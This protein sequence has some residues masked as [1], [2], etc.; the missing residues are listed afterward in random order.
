LTRI[1][2]VPYQFTVPATSDANQVSTAITNIQQII[3]ALLI[4]PP[5]TNSQL[6][7]RFFEMAGVPSSSIGLPQ[8][9]DI[10]NDVVNQGVYVGDGIVYF[11]PWQ[12]RPT[13]PNEIIAMYANNL[14]GN[15]LIA[16]AMVWLSQ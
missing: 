10:T 16:S 14:S 4:F 11:T 8:G 13:N 6:Q 5:G 1:F 3:G 12:K 7:Y 2:S 15:A 9:I